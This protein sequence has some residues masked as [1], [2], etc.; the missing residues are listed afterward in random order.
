MNVSIIIP[1]PHGVEQPECLPSIHASKFDAKKIEILVVSGN[2]PSTQRNLAAGKATGDIL[3]FIDDDSTLDPRA[4]CRLREAFEDF[5]EMAGVGGPS[6]GTQTRALFQKCAAM[7]MGSLFGFGPLRHRYYP[8][9]CPRRGTE[10][11]LI[12]SNLA[13]RREVWEAAGGFNPKL[14]PNEENEFIYRMESLGHRFLYHPGVIIYRGARKHLAALAVQVF[15][16]G[17]SRAHHL[18]LRVHPLNLMLFLPS[19]LVLSTL[20]V[21][22]DHAWVPTRLAPAVSAAV[23]SATGT[24]V[25]LAFLASCYAGL[26]VGKRRLATFALH[27]LIYPTL[28]FGYGVGFLL[29]ILTP[30]SRSDAERAPKLM[31]LKQLGDT[32]DWC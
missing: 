1:V 12:L 30:F 28:H 17:K 29:G 7:A 22:L 24:Y 31:W 8:S 21:V 20:L 3:Y 5:P 32:P 9:G 19:V 26:S 18:R 14:Y 23:Q 6:V 25:L 16:Y 11:E 10:N 27:L 13:V 2:S 15:R 4:L